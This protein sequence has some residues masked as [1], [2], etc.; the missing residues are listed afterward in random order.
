M[1]PDAPPPPAATPLPA[2]LDATDRRILAELEAD[3]RVP[4]AVLGRRV[5]LTAPAVR[6]RV[7]RLQRDGVIAGFHARLDSARMGRPIDAMIRVATP[8]QQ[9]QER[10]V[11]DVGERPEV[12]ACH[13]LTGED[14]FLIRVQVA[15]MAE[16]DRVTTSI[17]RFGRTTTSLVLG[18]VVERR[19]LADA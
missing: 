17:A 9:R 11:E 18:S 12:V 19:G 10:L 16:L 15:N 8:S 13:A 4:W 5:G 14:S 1:T 2:N 7:Q 3:A 6:Q